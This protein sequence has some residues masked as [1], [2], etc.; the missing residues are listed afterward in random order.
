MY[1]HLAEILNRHCLDISIG[2]DNQEAA[3]ENK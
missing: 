1:Q 3:G 2:K